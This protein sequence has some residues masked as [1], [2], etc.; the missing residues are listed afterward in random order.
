MKKTLGLLLLALTPALH[1]ADAISIIWDY[2]YDSTGFFTEQRKSV[3][4]EVGNIFANYQIDSSAITPGSGKSWYW[5][6]RNPTTNLNETVYNPT[7]AG[8]E[9]RIYLGARDLGS[10]L[11]VGG[12]VSYGASG[13]QQWIDSLAA[14]NTAEAYKPFA[15]R[16]S[17]NSETLWYDGLS[18]DVTEGFYDFYTVAAHEVGHVFGIGASNVA[19]WLANINAANHTFIG[20]DATNLY[21][22]PIPL[23]TDNAHFTYGTEYQG[24]EFIMDP[25][26]PA[27]ARKY[28]TAPE[29]AALQDLGYVAVPEPSTIILLI[30]GLGGILLIQRRRNLLPTTVRHHS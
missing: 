22:G 13:N 19:A 8:G 14:A 11:G 25:D 18:A 16:I 2:T 1:R 9:I 3:L 23:T 28:W 26:I 29:L 27:G 5:S 15:G 21:G 10:P 17:F 6:F 20:G 30:I 7:I 4:Q 24:Q 12:G